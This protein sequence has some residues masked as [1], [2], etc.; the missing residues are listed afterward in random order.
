M[1]KI[2]PLLTI[3]V[4]LYS[5]KEKEKTVNRKDN[6]IYLQTDTINVVRITDTMV[7][8][9]STCRGCAYENSTAFA[10]KDS[11]GVVRLETI[12]TADNNSEGM[13][14][15]NISKHLIIVP[16]KI[17]T[18]TMKMYKFWQGVP[19]TMSDSIAP[20]DTYKIE[21]QN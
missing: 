7:I 20:T 8:S 21:V 15:G 6:R 10:I 1:K 16:V 17:G 5:C 3:V 4:L 11:A 19:S 13:T 18:T 2:L 9:E 14:G 12:E